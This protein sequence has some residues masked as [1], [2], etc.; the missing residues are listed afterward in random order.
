MD[1]PGKRLR[2]AM[3]QAGIEKYAQL[4][5]MA[6]LEAGTVRAYAADRR[7]PPLHVCEKLA[8]PLKADAKWLFSG[9]LPSEAPQLIRS[10]ATSP[11]LIA[12]EKGL[13][14]LP[15]YG[16]SIDG[17]RGRIDLSKGVVE[18]VP[19]PLTLGE[20]PG[21]YAVFVVGDT[22]E[23]RYYAGE[24]AYIH[25][26]KPVKPGNFVFIQVARDARG[27][28]FDGYIKQLVS[29]SDEEV[30]CEQLKPRE[31]II[32]PREHV[33]TIHRIVLSGDG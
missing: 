19:A 6:K 31:R 25:P 12:P 8:G 26:A 3:K 15:V 21:S 24:I 33:R 17:G 16:A 11:V 10:N 2:L 18:R 13:A 14:L 7:A 23:P 30:I 5:R 1:T 29:I 28:Q 4:A 20:V 9:L 27:M 32:F 22:M